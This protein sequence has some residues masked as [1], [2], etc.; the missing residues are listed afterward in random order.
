MFASK[1]FAL[2]AAVIASVSAAPAGTPTTGNDLVSRTGWT[3][4]THSVVVGRG[5]LHF[6]PENV[7][8]EI[9][10]TIEWHFQA[11][12]HSI[13]QSDF[14]HPCKPLADG[15]SFF[16]G[17]NFFTEGTGQNPNVYQITVIDNNPIWYYCPQTKGNHCQMGMVGVVNQNFNSQ[18]TLSN[19]K[20]IAAGTGVSTVGTIQGGKNGGFIRANPNPNSGF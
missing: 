14:A 4:V 2:F 7:V 6:D 18:N 17:F 9:G 10:D 8:A 19:Q 12:N 13:A 15:T 11:A 1:A 3:G 16:A 5:G 20:V